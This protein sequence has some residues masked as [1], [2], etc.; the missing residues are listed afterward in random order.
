MVMSKKH[1]S[2]QIDQ[3]V[4]EHS[5][6]M[7][8]HNQCYFWRILGRELLVWHSEVEIVSS[9]F[10][11]PRPHS[12]F[13][14]QQ[15]FHHLRRHYHPLRSHR[16]LRCNYHPLYFASVFTLATPRTRWR[17]FSF[18]ARSLLSIKKTAPLPF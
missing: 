17:F 13:L 12:H 14:C 18:G 8:E 6:T 7:L 4:I 2:H 16:Q 1:S 3:V 15:T 10:Y 5:L 11:P 9:D